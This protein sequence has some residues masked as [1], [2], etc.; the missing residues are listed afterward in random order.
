MRFTPVVLEGRK[1]GFFT[2]GGHW[3]PAPFG[4][5]TEMRVSGDRWRVLYHPAIYSSRSPQALLLGLCHHR[6]RVIIVDPSFPPHEVAD[7]LAHEHTHAII[8]SGR[9]TEPELGRL[10]RAQEE[11]LCRVF[12]RELTRS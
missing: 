6:E 11:A 3:T 9:E 4:L 8:Q 2:R 1:L 10:T 12:A 5:P 7:T